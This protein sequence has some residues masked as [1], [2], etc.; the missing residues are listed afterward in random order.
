MLCVGDQAASAP[1]PAAF[2]ALLNQ[3]GMGQGGVPRAQCSEV[4]PGSTS[5]GLAVRLGPQSPITHLVMGFYG[6]AVGKLGLEGRLPCLPGA[7]LTL[8]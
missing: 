6:T 5:R 1:Q 2:H 8:G 3:A 7:G 4:H